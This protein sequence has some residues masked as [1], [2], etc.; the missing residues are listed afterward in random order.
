MSGENVKILLLN[1]YSRNALA[2]INSL[3]P[4]YILVGAAEGGGIL[5]SSRLAEVVDVPSETKDPEACADA[6]IRHAGR[7]NIDAVIAAGTSSTEHLSEY[8]QKIADATGAK[9]LVEDY[10]K[11]S[12]MADKW[13]MYEMCCELSIMAPRA[14]LLTDVNEVA[15]QARAGGLAYP[16]VLKPRRSFGAIGVEIFRSEQ[17]VAAFQAGPAARSIKSETC[18]LQEYISG[19]LHD[20]TSCCRDGSVLSIL[21][22]E[23]LQTCYDFGGGGI[24]NR[25]T[26]E[27]DITASA[28]R[29]I[30]HMKWNGIAEFDFI[31]TADGV[32]YLL[33]CNPKIWGTTELTV[34]AGLNMP[35]QLVDSMYFDREVLPQRDY[36]V[37]LVYKWIFPECI[38]HWL[39]RPFTGGNLYRRIRT[40]LR[41]YEGTR[42]ITNL[43][44]RNML[45][46]L[47]RTMHKFAG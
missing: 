36:Q 28:G 21:S 1:C 41:H 2:V 31:R 23:R 45:H 6:I 5:K 34:E 24:V 13:H 9:V 39:S 16:Y 33:E 27:D 40:T 29:I 30:E 18:M 32:A 43:Q 25:T 37:G 44:R 35:Q 20:V 7:L 11:V 47:G 22:Q 38:Q 19:S 12:K 15:D 14:V 4:S 8:K 17:E 46:L 26:R 3:D 42:T 10:D